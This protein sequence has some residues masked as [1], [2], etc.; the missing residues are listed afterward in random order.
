MRVNY[1]RCFGLRIVLLYAQH[2]KSSANK[3]QCN[4]HGIRIR[5][6][7]P[8]QFHFKRIKHTDNDAIQQLRRMRDK[9]QLSNR[10]LQGRA[11]RLSWNNKQGLSMCNNYNLNF[12]YDRNHYIYNLNLNLNL[13]HLVKYNCFLFVR[14]MLPFGCR[15]LLPV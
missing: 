1:S 13:N 2:R 12:N 4:L 6:C 5:I 7:R 9:G 8:F 10:R 11:F 14:R 3:R 15:Q